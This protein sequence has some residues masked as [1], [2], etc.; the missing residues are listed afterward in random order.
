M[1]DGN[2]SGRQD[3][4]IGMAYLE[5]QQGIGQI[6]GE[7]RPILVLFRP[8]SAS[9]S[10]RLLPPSADGVR[11]GSPLVRVSDSNMDGARMMIA[12]EHIWKPNRHWAKF[13]GEIARF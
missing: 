1:G 2:I 6:F 7:N 8:F 5:T 12:G 11:F 3:G 9:V 10:V 4:D 13:V